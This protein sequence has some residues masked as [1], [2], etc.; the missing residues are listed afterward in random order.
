[1]VF[2]G[3]LQFLKLLDL[4]TSLQEPKNMNLKLN[5]IQGYYVSDIKIT[6]RRVHGSKFRGIYLESIAN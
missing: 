6:C 3:V 1:M 5:N 2:Y 4:Q